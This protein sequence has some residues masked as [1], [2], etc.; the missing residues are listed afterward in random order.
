MSVLT[1]MK[2]IKHGIIG[3][4]ILVKAPLPAQNDSRWVKAG[5]LGQIYIY[6]VKSLHGNSV[7]SATIEKHGLKNG[8]WFDRQ[9]IFIDEKSQMVK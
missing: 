6:P 4:E 9:F 8:D 2:G 3:D 1:K 5:K 7:N